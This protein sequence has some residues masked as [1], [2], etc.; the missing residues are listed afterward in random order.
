MSSSVL[1]EFIDLG[2]R[3]ACEGRPGRRS[4]SVFRGILKIAAARPT[5]IVASYV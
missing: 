1:V 5:V 2:Q 3:S 4:L